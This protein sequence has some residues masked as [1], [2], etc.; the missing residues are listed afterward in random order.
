MSSFI[1]NT[2]I[3]SNVLILVKL[4]VHCLAFCRKIAKIKIKI[5]SERNDL[6]ALLTSKFWSCC[7]V[8]IVSANSNTANTVY[9]LTIVLDVLVI[10]K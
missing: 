7:D 10:T 8:S 6:L 2:Q 1:I 5:M 3:L 9:H 4:T